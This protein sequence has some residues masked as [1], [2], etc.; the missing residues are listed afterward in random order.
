MK[1]NRNRKL[2]LILI[3]VI[4]CFYGLKNYAEKV[5]DEHS[6]TTSISSKL[7]DFNT[8]ELKVDSNLNLSDF[9]VVNQNSGKTIFASG[10]NLKGIDNNYGHRLFELY[11]KDKKIYEFGH[12]ST[13]NWYTFDYT[14]N[15]NKINNRIEPDLKIISGQN[16][17]YNDFFYKRFEYND[18]G[19]LDRISYLTLGKE[20]YDVKEIN[21]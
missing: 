2:F 11:Y 8:F 12:F 17:S 21:E 6:I 1:L 14:L 9:K 5:K 3:A 15:L 19:K 20:V 13:N 18:S 10:K 7:F 4:L 16:D